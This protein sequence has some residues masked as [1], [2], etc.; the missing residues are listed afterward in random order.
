M[1]V[2]SYFGANQ[3]PETVDQFI[4]EA[5]L[6]GVTDTVNGYGPEDFASVDAIKL[7]AEK[8]NAVA[9]TVRAAGLTYNLHN[10]FWEFEIVDGRLAIEWLLEECPDVTLELD[11]YWCT[12]FGSQI[13]SEMAKKFSDR[14]RLLHVKDGPMV[15]DEPMVAAGSG[16]V[17]L[18]EAIPLCD[19]NWLIL[20]LDFCA[21]DMMEAVRESYQYLVGSGLAF[22]NKSV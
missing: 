12:N 6:L 5:F 9:S 10:H 18:A 19:P 15:K 14:V 20:E 2:T 7:T 21:T 13:A 4:E 22:G 3:T 16:K 8:V 11:L 17:D 1:E